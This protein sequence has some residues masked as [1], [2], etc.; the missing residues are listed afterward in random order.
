MKLLNVRGKMVDKAV[1]QY[2]IDWDAKSKSIIQFQVKQFLKPF[3]KG[4]IMYEEFPV[5]GTQQKVDLVNATLRIAIEVN[6]PQHSQF[7]YFHGG[8][9]QEYLK[10]VKLDMQKTEWLEKNNFKLIEINWDEVPTLSKEFFQKF[11]VAL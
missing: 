8:N 5:F 6:G 3:W 2:A 4:C 11:N 9:P 1:N 7:H 10:A